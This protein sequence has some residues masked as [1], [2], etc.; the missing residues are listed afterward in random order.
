MYGCKSQEAICIKAHHVA[1]VA[2]AGAT[3][4]REKFR[5]KRDLFRVWSLLWLPNWQGMGSDG[6]DV[7]TKD[8]SETAGVHAA[9]HMHAPVM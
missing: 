7:G 8:A 4:M 5:G 6:S 1:S 9:W 2:A 3:L